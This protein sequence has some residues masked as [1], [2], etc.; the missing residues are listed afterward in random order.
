M[1]RTTRIRLSAILMLTIGLAA[2]LASTAKSQPAGANITV[3]N[4]AKVPILFVIVSID[5]Q[6]KPTICQNAST[7]A[8]S[9]TTLALCGAKSEMWINTG[10]G[11]TTRTPLQ[12]GHYY[13]IYSNGSSWVVEDQGQR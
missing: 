12:P 5:P 8:G 3:G 2:G 13:T 4:Y 10:N 9:T 11:G 1:T 7:P 6:G